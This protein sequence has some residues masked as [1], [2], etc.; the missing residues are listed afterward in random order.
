MKRPWVVRP[1]GV[2]FIRA[3][4]YRTHDIALAAAEALGR[5]FGERF[6][7]RHRSERWGYEV[8]PMFEGA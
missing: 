8:V 3:R 6:E 1:V 7:V 4:T 5:E 2:P